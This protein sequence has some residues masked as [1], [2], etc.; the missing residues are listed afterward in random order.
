MQDSLVAQP[1]PIGSPRLWVVCGAVFS[2]LLLARELY[3]NLN[4]PLT[5]DDA[6]M[7]YRYAAHIREGM[8][9]AWNAG[10]APTYGITSHGWLLVVTLLAGLPISPGAILQS[11]SWITGAVALAL[12]GH[13]LARRGTSGWSAALAVAAPLALLIAPHFRYHL[14]TGMDTMLAFAVNVVIA[15]GVVDYLRRPERRRAFVL[16]GLAV[17]AFLGRPDGGL[18]ALGAPLLAWLLHGPQ[19]RPGDLAGLILVPGLLIGLSIGLCH[20]YFGVP[21]PLSFYAKSAGGYEGFQGKD[22]ALGYFVDFLKVALPFL[23]VGCLARIRARDAVVFF[24]PVVLTL[25]YLLSVNQVMGWFGR[26]YIP[27]LPYIV[28]P[29]LLAFDRRLTCPEP[30]ARAETMTAFVLGIAAASAFVVQSQIV[31]WHLAV[32]MPAPVPEPTMPIAAET[33]L[34]ESV[35]FDYIERIAQDI[36]SKV[37]RGTVIA[38]SEVGY[39]GLMAPQAEIIDLVGLNDTEIGRDG[40]TTD[41][42]VERKPDLIWLP[43]QPYTGMRAEI[44]SN[45]AFHEH[46]ALISGAYGFGLAIRRDSPRKA[47]LMAIIEDAWPRFYPRIRME[48][49]IVQTDRLPLQGQR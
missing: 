12:M 4:I 21:L 8:G 43:P 10:G 31:R 16:G 32:S 24:I 18:C 38:A 1:R 20:I 42:L 48:D 5:F 49:H 6:F 46:Y 13:G 27:L 33:P 35:W 26:F 34:P 29:L 15:F 39:L 14:T 37:P 19:R 44:L 47:Q 41:R 30:V 36:A 2:A 3:L 9:I 11:A 25:A 22:S 17:L 40:F 28:I 23:L 45:R 7:F